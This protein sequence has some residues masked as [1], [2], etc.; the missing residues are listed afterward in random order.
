M[1]YSGLYKIKINKVDAY[2]KV[3]DTNKHLMDTV[4]PF[5]QFTNNN[6]KIVLQNETI[7][8]TET[9]SEIL[10]ASCEPNQTFDYVANVSNRLRFSFTAFLSMMIVCGDTAEICDK[11]N[12]PTN[13]S[14]KKLNTEIESMKNDIE[15]LRKDVDE[16]KKQIGDMSTVLS[17][18]VEV[19]E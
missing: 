12:N 1:T 16:L 6:T 19:G 18:V 9:D 10:I 4:N 5:Y 8:N 17:T 11:L 3:V 13:T 15:S 2:A 14:I 7:S